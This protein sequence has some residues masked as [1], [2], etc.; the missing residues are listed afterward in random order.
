MDLL[1][2]A[3]LSFIKF[4]VVVFTQPELEPSPQVSVDEYLHWDGLCSCVSRH[5]SPCGV[6]PWGFVLL[7]ARPRVTADS[8]PALI[9]IIPL[10][11]QWKKNCFIFVVDASWFFYATIVHAFLCHR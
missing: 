8:A 1:V 3:W 6:D 7:E 4:K 11:L 10:L 2:E 9:Y 5:Y